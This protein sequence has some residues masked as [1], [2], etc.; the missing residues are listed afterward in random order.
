MPHATDGSSKQTAVSERGPAKNPGRGPAA[1][2]QGRRHPP[3]VQPAG[4]LLPPTRHLPAWERRPPVTSGPG[5]AAACPAAAE[6][7]LQ[8]TPRPGGQPAG[9]GVG[10]GG[11]GR[12]AHPPLR[13]ALRAWQRPGLETTEGK[14]RGGGGGVQRAPGRRR[15]QS[16]RYRFP[17]RPAPGRH[18]R[19]DVTRPGRVPSAG[20]CV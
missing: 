20:G 8:A 9:P 13:P 10:G 1:S 6:C 7:P 11:G 19:K 3:R 14:S 5:W 18:A 2:T 4:T 17:S 16:R 15:C 12:R